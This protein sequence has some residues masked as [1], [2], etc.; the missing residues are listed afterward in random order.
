MRIK[1]ISNII[2]S[3]VDLYVAT[4]AFLH[5]VKKLWVFVLYL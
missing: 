4:T 2:Q 3:K 5:A 1:S